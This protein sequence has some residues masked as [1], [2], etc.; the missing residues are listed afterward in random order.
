MSAAEEITRD[1]KGRALAQ[2][3]YPTSGCAKVEEAMAISTLSRSKIYLMMKSGELETKVF[4]KSRRITW[5]SIREKFLTSE[6]GQ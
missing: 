6:V 3:G 5:A 1:E 4:G 2:D